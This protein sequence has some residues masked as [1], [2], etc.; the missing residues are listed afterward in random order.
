MSFDLFQPE[1]DNS[2]WKI[3]WENF[4]RR[5]F[6]QIFAHFGQFSFILKQLLIFQIKSLV[7]KALCPV[8]LSTKLHRG[9][10]WCM[11]D[12]MNRRLRLDMNK[13]L[14]LYTMSGTSSCFSI[15]YSVPR[16]H[17]R[18]YCFL[19]SSTTMSTIRSWESEWK[20]PRILE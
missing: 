3:L 18:V 15:E 10:Q 4:K 20:S 16:F 13:Y 6:L 7:F 2:N 19:L 9:I 14:Y 1:P 12:S 17:Y 11:N 8:L 5:T